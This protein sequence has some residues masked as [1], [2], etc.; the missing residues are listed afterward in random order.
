M[1]QNEASSPDPPPCNDGWPPRPRGADQ[2]AAQRRLC[3]RRRRPRA[4]ALGASVLSASGATPG[5]V[6]RRVHL[7]VV[8]AK[9][10]TATVPYV[11]RRAIWCSRSMWTACR[12]P[13]KVRRNLIQLRQC[14]A[15]GLCSGTRPASASAD[16]SVSRERA[17]QCKHASA[18]R[19]VGVRLSV[20]PE[21]RLA[22]GHSVCEPVITLQVARTYVE[23]TSWR[24]VLL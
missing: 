3:H 2:A 16:A 6:N 23:V 4:A 7:S 10:E 19:T 17:E 8:T 18:R 24:V 21:R 12:R 11:V 9:I 1:R 14:A 5:D 13:I 20:L 22:A 15:V